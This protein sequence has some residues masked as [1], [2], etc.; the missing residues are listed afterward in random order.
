MLAKKLSR[1]RVKKQLRLY[2]PMPIYLEPGSIILAREIG[3][4][5]ILVDNKEPLDTLN[6]KPLT[7]LTD[8]NIMREYLEELSPDHDEKGVRINNPNATPDDPCYGC[9]DSNTDRC[10]PGKCTF[11]G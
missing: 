5:I 8:V 2:H 11:E 6:R 4:I 7:V 10:G 1:F 9:P 3:A